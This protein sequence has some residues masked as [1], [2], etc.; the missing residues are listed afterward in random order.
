MKDMGR[1]E[2]LRI[3]GILG[4]GI[5]TSAFFPSI[6]E[7]VR[8]D[9]SLY[10]V[11][12]MKIKMGTFV[13]I[14]VID[15][16]KDR[17]DEAIGRAFDTIDRLCRILSRFESGT[18]VFQLNREGKIKGCCPELLDTIRESIYFSRLTKG[19][20]D[21]TVKPVVDLFKERYIK[22]EDLDIPDTILK[23][24]LDKVGYRNIE[25]GAGEI[26]FKK[27]GMGITLDG[28]AKGYIVDRA[29]EVL[30]REGVK[31]F[32]INAGGDIRA[33]GKN[34]KREAWKIAVQDPQKDSKWPDVIK[35]SEGAIAT[36]G[37]Y[38]VYFDKERLFHHIV[39]PKT[40]LSP[41]RFSSVSVIAPT[42][43]EADA[44][45]TGVFVMGPDRGL[46]FINSLR[47]YHCLLIE[48]GGRIYRSRSW[49]SFSI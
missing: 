35:L 34:Y 15:P 26:R 18:E 42:V 8:F 20:F 30:K 1:R 45:S 23:R 37:N 21:I 17:A 31:N 24:A 47:R 28:I 11:S 33:T 41:L 39:D 9:R 48:R 3:S 16:S 7:A 6:S 13:N 2:F 46:H 49:K 19:A 5:W 38:E 43:M 40:G 22:G 25:I 32:L 29:S 36:S 10:K 44:L 27:E 4:L 14:I 12:R